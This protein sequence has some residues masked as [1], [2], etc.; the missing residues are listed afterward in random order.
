[1]LKFYRIISSRI[2]K[3]IVGDER[4]EFSVHEEAIAQLSTPLHNMMKGNMIEAMNG[5]TVWENVNKQTFKLFVQFAYLGDYSVLQTQERPATVDVPESI[6]STVASEPAVGDT[7]IGRPAREP[8]PDVI[9][10]ERVS[11]KENLVRDQL[12]IMGTTEIPEPQPAEFREV[13]LRKDAAKFDNLSYPYNYEKGCEPS[14]DFH[15]GHSYSELLLSHASLHILGNYYLIDSLKALTLYKLHKTLCILKLDDGTIND[16]ID[17]ARHIYCEGGSGF[18]DEIGGLRSLV[19]Q[20]MATNVIVL[21]SHEGFAALLEEGG[22][23]VVVFFK[24]L[25]LLV[26]KIH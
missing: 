3:F 19:C 14:L 10:V 4:T 8:S 11:K 7:T 22:P 25:V 16:V 13:T 12:R 6:S 17:L 20:Y 2:F 9:Q 21:A 15:S 18:D 1:V 26:Q 24:F 23:F 5:C